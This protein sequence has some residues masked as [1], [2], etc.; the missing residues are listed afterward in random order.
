M[1]VAIPA[2]GLTT[3]LAGGLFLG[4]LGLSAAT[5]LAQK[6][7]AETTAN[8]TYQSSL[9]AN[10]SAEDAKRLQQE[11]LSEQK[12]ETEKSSA[13]DIFA[14]NIESLIA[15]RKIVA[16][17]RAGT[18]VGLLLM[19]QERQAANYRESINQ[20]LES[21]RRQYTRNIEGTES[22]FLNRR[23]QL[24]SNINQ[25]YNQIP[26]LGSTLL[27][28]ATQGLSTYGTLQGLV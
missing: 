7:A 28:V 12:S 3:K 21:A 16:S 14:K 26:S 19:D 27:N 1:C 18:T 13:Q 6:S 2:L 8:Q 25:A 20:T 9:I 5:G 17:E 10:Q 15:S 11:A 4:S 22:Q 23:N 24:T